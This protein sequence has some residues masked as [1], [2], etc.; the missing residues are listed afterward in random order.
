MQYEK[1]TAKKSRQ[2]VRIHRRSYST[3]G[4][5]P[6]KVVFHQR[7]SFTFHLSW[8]YI[9]GNSQHTKSQPPLR[10]VIKYFWNT[11]STNAQSHILRHHAAL[12]C[13][14]AGVLSTYKLQRYKSCEI[15]STFLAIK[16]S[17]NWKRENGCVWSCPAELIVCPVFCS[18]KEDYK[19]WWGWIKLCSCNHHISFQLKEPLSKA[20]ST[21]G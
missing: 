11:N 2:H 17:A 3:E 21:E 18:L 14:R 13:N 9:C 20:T 5:L 1:N 6:L 7:S 12:K 15:F 8:S 10:S 16:G 19:I 4:P